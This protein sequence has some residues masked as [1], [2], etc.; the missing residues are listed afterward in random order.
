MTGSRSAARWW[1]TRPLAGLFAAA[2]MLP[3]PGQTLSVL[4]SADAVR[5][6][7][8]DLRFVE[9]A[10][11]DRLRDGGSLRLDFDLSIFAE[12]GGRA[13]ATASEA[14]ALSFDLWEERVAVTRAGATPRSVSHLT[15]RDAERWCL[16][17]LSIPRPNLAALPRG[18]RFWLR[19]EYRV[20]DATSADESNDGVFTLRSLID[21]LSRRGPAARL[22]KSMDAG[23]FRLSD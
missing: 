7:S 15:P 5:V 8:P 3:A 17:Q 11:L 21:A 4:P 10:V 22:G 23:P 2:L 12:P 16:S 20:G 13:I 14:F 18:A 9:G 1:R 6:Q 19:L